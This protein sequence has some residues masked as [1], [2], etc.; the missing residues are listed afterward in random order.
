MASAINPRDQELA[1]W[2]GLAPGLTRS[3][4][5]A[6]RR[7]PEAVAITTTDGPVTWGQIAR[8]AAAMLDMLPALDSRPELLAER[9]TFYRLG[10]DPMMTGYYAP[11]VEASLTPVPEYPYPFYARP[12]DLRVLDLSA[13][14]PRHKGERLVYRMQDGAPV[15]YHDR[16]AIDLGGA[17]AGRGLE[18]AWAKHPWDIYHLQVQGSGVLKLPDGTT[19][20]IQ[21]GGKNGRVFSSATRAMLADGTLARGQVHRVGIRRALD[22]LG[23]RVARQ[24]LAVNP[25]YVFF[26][27]GDSLPVGAMNRPLTPLV[28]VATD[29]TVFPL[30]SLMTITASLPV[31]PDDPAKAVEQNLATLRTTR[32]VLALAQDTGGVIKGGRIDYYTGIGPDKQYIA[33]RIKND[34]TACLLILKEPAS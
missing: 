20:S 26:Q 24:R 1:G 23:M 17:L 6:S 31:A 28:S 13:F 22:G 12:P 21:Y 34:V 7:A 2:Q 5:Y 27:L 18:I 14:H 3:L 8:S 19:R 16:A 33:F 11:L 29:P 25:S 30:G 9:F 4:E 32:T 10:P 15:P